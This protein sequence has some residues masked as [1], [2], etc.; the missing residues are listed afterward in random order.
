MYFDRDGW[1]LW[2]QGT[3]F[4]TFEADQVQPKASIEYF[5]SARQQLRASLQWVGIRAKEQDFYLVPAKAGA[6]IPTTKPPGPSDDFLISDITFQIR[7]RWEMAPLSDLFVVYTRVANR[8]AALLDSGFDDLF[9]DSYD[10]P[11]Q[12]LFVVKIRY[13]LGS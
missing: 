8:T 9:D 3:N 5:I 13:R 1:L 4:T 6:L 12:N 2:Q 7:Y 10:D 11:L